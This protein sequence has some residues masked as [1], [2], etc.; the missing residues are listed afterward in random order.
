MSRR[1]IGRL[2]GGA[3]VVF[4]ALPV[5][6]Q[7]LPT[8]KPE[9][10][11]MSSQ[12]LAHIMPALKQEVD[13]GRIPGAVVMVAR[14][15]KLVLA[16]S[17]GFQDK[18]AG[19]PMKADAIFRIYSMTKPLVS[20]AAMMLVE[21]GKIQLTDPLSKFFPACKNMMVSV[22]RADSVYARVTY[23]LVPADREITV[24]D[25]LRHT[26]GLAYGEITQNVPVRDAYAKAGVY[27]PGVRDYDSRDV[28][29]ADFVERLCKAPLA[30]QPSTLWEYSL[31]VDMLGR[32]VE[33]ASGQRLADFLE[34][35][36]FKP[37]KMTD[38]GFWVPGAKMARLAQPLAVDAATGAKTNVIDVSAAPKNDSGGAGGV[39]TASDYLRFAQA[40]LNGGQLDGQRILSR[41][42]VALMAS[43]HLGSRIATPTQP[44]EL[45]MGV[46]GYTFGLGFMVRQAQGVAGV[47]GSQGEFMWAGYAGTF[48]WID[49][50]EE[51]AVVYM[52]Q[53]PSPIRPMY[54]RLMKQFVYAAIID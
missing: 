35:R 42:T 34:E 49:P 3:C 39:S 47:P 51:L 53:A 41:S 43:D 5:L 4:A 46:Q 20:V 52:T 26:S 8:A 23:N 19:T 31:S 37:L 40:M 29:P 45:L 12:K 7:P 44:G 38:T 18:N 17:V 21:E 13:A 54:R 50:K 25:L 11:G 30:Q 9:Q 10:V 16:D 32:V 22:P 1:R 15:G 28:T 36:L 33:A 2:L 6:A 48:F 24:Q 14:K 27:Q